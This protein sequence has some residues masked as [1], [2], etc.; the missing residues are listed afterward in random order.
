MKTSF[1][2]S[3]LGRLLL[4]FC[5]LLYSQFLFSQPLSGNYTIGGLNPDFASP[6]DAANALKVNGVSGPVFF[7]IRPGIYMKNGGNNTV[8]TLDSIVTGLS[9]TNR[10]TFQPDANEGGNVG[11]TI[12]QMNIID[13]PTSNIELVLVKLDFITF[14]NITFQESDASINTGTLTLV[15]LQRNSFLGLPPVSGTVFEGCRF[16]GTDPTAG[17][18]NGIELG[19]R[20]IDITIRGNTFLRLLRG[21]SGSNSSSSAGSM[22][23]EDN[24]FL[25]GW[26]TFSGSGNALGFAMEIFSEN[27]IIRKN[28]IDFNGSFNS[29]Y[30]GISIL[31]MTSSETI[32]VEQ[33]S[34]EGT[35]SASIVV[36]GQGG[37]PDSFIVANNMI[38]AV[39]YPV[40][41]NE[42]AVGIRIDLN[43]PNAQ[44]LFNT[45]VLRGGGLIGLHVDAEN[46]SVLNNIII[47]KP[48]SGSNY[49]YVQGSN[50]NTNFQSDYNVLF[51]TNNQ[52][53]VVCPAGHFFDLGSYQIATGLDT[54]SIS[55]NIDFVDSSDLHISDCQ[56]QDPDLK[57]IP[58]AGITEDIDEEVRSTTTPMIGADENSFAGFNMF[59]DPFSAGLPG[60]AFDIAAD[61]FDNILYDGIAIPD[62][63]NQ[64]VHLYHNLPPRSFELDNSLSTPFKPVAVKFYDLDEDNNLDLIVSGDTSAVSV[65]WGDGVGGF[66]S[67]ITVETLGRVRSLEPGP[68]FSGDVQR[69]IV[70]TEDNGFAPTQ[71]TIGYLM[72]LGNRNLCHDTQY[73]AV[74]PDTINVL[75]TDFVVGEFAGDGDLP[76]YATVTIFPTPHPL[77]IASDIIFA[78]S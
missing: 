14:K 5:F 72:H 57:G 43:P 68:T 62:Y 52:Q 35:V 42:A 34:I 70:L 30:R 31:V 51:K 19:S 22:I 77:I 46:S 8:L 24:Q 29:G 75:M 16:I 28:I 17:T 12:L 1:C 55:K 6:Q 11:N 3:S 15:Q 71:S 78:A 13:P 59:A 33:N 2:R 60:T 47:T 54:N 66:S 45:V 32:V 25:E 26:H 64:Q 56:A 4:T 37:I 41:A 76:E 49:C 73:G 21:I 27:L 7:N 61:N 23:I 58:V 40:W 20:V 39:A 48:S 9:E 63:D 53:L 69:T 36:I 38:N 44:V 65:F 74:G 18:E 10:V 67:P 50:T